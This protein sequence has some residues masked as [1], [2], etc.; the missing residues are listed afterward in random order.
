MFGVIWCMWKLL[1]VLML[2]CSVRLMCLVIR[3]DGVLLSRKL[4]LMCGW[5]V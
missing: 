5:C 3:L 1:L 4:M 2:M